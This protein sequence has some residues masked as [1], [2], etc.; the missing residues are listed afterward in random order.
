MARST[1]GQTMNTDQLLGS[2]N[3]NRVKE[4]GKESFSAEDILKNLAS[5]DC[6]LRRDAALSILQLDHENT[7]KFET[8][9]IIDA[10]TETLKPPT[11]W[12]GA[13]ALAWATCAEAALAALH[14]LADAGLE[15]VSDDLSRSLIPFVDASQPWS[16]TAAASTAARLLDRY[17]AEAQKRQEFITRDLLQHYL[18][19]IFSKSSSSITAQGRPALYREPPPEGSFHAQKAAWKEAGPYVVTVFDWAVEASE[20]TTIKQ[21]WPLYVPVLVTLAEDDDVAV[22]QRGIDILNRF[23]SKCPREVLRTSG[24][25][26]V[27]EESVFPSLLFL[28]TLTPEDE[29]VALLRS[30]YRTLRT[31]AV[32][33]DADPAGR[34]RRALLDK[35][36]REGVLAGYLHA[37]QHIRVVEVLMRATAQ[38]V[39]ALQV[40]AVKHLQSLLDLFAP[41]LADA[42]ALAYVPAVVAAAQALN[43]TILNCWPRIVGTPHA[44]HIINIPRPGDSRPGT[45]KDNGLDGIVVEGG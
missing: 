44:E 34:N 33:A 31:L 8:T 32:A 13:D 7:F 10:L 38:V 4:L 5:G 37:S 43:S 17:L 20:A 45:E 23:L 41:V 40:Y 18:R 22:R 26:S 12:E 39:E 15:S 11:A 2:D 21:H 1:N 35:T 27:F 9:A 25:D 19:P 36:L 3:R 24:I 16:T 42:F 6:S 14:T 28:P 29:S 30:A